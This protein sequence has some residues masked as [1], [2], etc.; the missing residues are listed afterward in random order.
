MQVQS[1]LVILI[2][3][4]QY[5]GTLYRDSV[6]V[7]CTLK[8]VQ[9]AALKGTNDEDSSSEYYDDSE[10]CKSMLDSNL[11]SDLFLAYL[12]RPL[13]LKLGITDRFMNI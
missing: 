9:K 12:R 10:V 11:K 6:D 8:L 4:S 3:H 5:D 7:G 2:M 1:V 13:Y